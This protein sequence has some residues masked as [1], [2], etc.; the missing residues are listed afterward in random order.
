VA[1][2]HGR[3]CNDLARCRDGA[4]SG[5]RRAACSRGE[6]EWRWRRDLGGWGERKK[7]EGEA[8]GQTGGGLRGGEGN[9]IGLGVLIYY[10]N[11][12]TSV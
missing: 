8:A 3:G 1:V 11:A 7:R 10:E 5:A 12:I 2:L 6:G 9:R 4:R